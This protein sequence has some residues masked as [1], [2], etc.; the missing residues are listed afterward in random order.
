[1]RDGSVVLD[2]STGRYRLIPGKSVGLLAAP[3]GRY[4]A[5]FDAAGDIGIADSSTG[6]VRSFPYGPQAGGNGFASDAQWSPDGA[7]LLVTRPTG[8]RILDAGTGGHRDWDDPRLTNP[9]SVT[10]LPDGTEIA[11]AVPGLAGTLTISVY[12]ADTREKLRTLPVHGAP[13]SQNAWSPDGRYVLLLPED[14][15]KPS[16]RVAEVATGRRV[17]SLPSGGGAFFVT[18]GQIHVMT[19][20]TAKLYG[21][22]GKLL[23]QTALPSGFAGRQISVGRL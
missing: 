20:R 5:V 8:I 13:V 11:V 23:Q 1:V 14:H 22:S 7:R 19:G 16:V 9:R 4:S 15:A 2:R 17:S 10:W 21:L 18:A 6:R 3:A 12:A